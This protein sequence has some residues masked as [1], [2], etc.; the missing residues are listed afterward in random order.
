MSLSLLWVCVF[1]HTSVWKSPS[2]VSGVLTEDVS[3]GLLR[4]SS[5][6]LCSLEPHVCSGVMV[7]KLSQDRWSSVVD[8]SL[9]EDMAGSLLYLSM[10][11]NLVEWLSSW[12]SSECLLRVCITFC[13]EGEQQIKK[14]KKKQTNEMKNKK[15]QAG[16]ELG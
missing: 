15:G 14:K 2:D 3:Q 16:V 9:K 6:S 4:N 8:L 1:L 11:W 5:L 13:K 7:L 10:V 12:Y